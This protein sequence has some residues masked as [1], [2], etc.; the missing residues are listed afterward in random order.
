MRAKEVTKTTRK[1]V[2]AKPGSPTPK[3]EGQAT[4]E[5]ANLRAERS[6]LPF[7]VFIS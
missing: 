7:V 3:P 5:M 2:S 4:Y 6:G 1:N